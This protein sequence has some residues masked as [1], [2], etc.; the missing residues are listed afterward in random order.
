MHESAVGNDVTWVFSQSKL[1]P[2]NDIIVFGC[3][4]CPGLRASCLLS[5]SIFSL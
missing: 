5:K 2:F 3:P 4:G 1:L